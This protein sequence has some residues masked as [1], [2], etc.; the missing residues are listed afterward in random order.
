MIYNVEV[1]DDDDDDDDN[2]NNYDDVIE[3][4]GIPE[5]VHIDD[6]RSCFHPNCNCRALSSI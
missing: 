5:N 1:N 6:Q 4:L 2:D 3:H